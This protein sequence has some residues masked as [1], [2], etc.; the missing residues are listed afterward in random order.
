[1]YAINELAAQWFESHYEGSWAQEHLTGRTHVDLAGDRGARPGCAPDR[2]RGLVEHLQSEGV[3][4]E[5]MLQVGVAFRSGRGR[6]VDLMRDRVVMPV[7]DDTG[8]IAGF[9]G[10]ENP[11]N[12]GTAKYINTKRTE[13]FD[14]GELFCSALP[15]RGQVAIVEGPA[16]ALA[17]TI[18]SGGRVVGAGT[19]GTALTQGHAERLA[20]LAQEPIVWRDNDGPGWEAAERDFRLLAQYGVEPLMTTGPEGA[21]PAD[22]LKTDGAAGIQTRLDQARPAG[23]LLIEHHLAAGRAGAAISVAAEREPCYWA[24]DAARIAERSGLETQAV[25]NDLAAAVRGAEPGIVSLAAPGADS[26]SAG[27]FVLHDRERSALVDTLRFEYERRAPEQFDESEV[28]AALASDPQYAYDEG[29]TERYMARERVHFAATEKQTL[30][31]LR[32]IEDLADHVQR[33]GWVDLDDAVTRSVIADVVAD[34]GWDLSSSDPGVA[35][36]ED[37]RGVI[38]AVQDRTAAVAGGADRT[39]AQQVSETAGAEAM[40]AADTGRASVREQ[41]QTL[42]AQQRAGVVERS[43]VVAAQPAHSQRNLSSSTESERGM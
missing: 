4:E 36:P 27:G 40:Q 7:H 28:Y 23:E 39:V 29:A 21:D 34:A 14:K 18:G 42:A 35:P 22:V 24:P 9:V 11:D 15:V 32:P 41:L 6:V 13:L 2:W 12:P 38:Q 5:E 26:R 17:I 25:R 19:L 30:E 31:R 37:L 33:T 3:S 20:E 8:R 1:M 10:R 16:D 43:P